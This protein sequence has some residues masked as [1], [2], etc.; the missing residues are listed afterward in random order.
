MI[1][2][3]KIIIGLSAKELPPVPNGANVRVHHKKS[4]STKAKVIDKAASPRNS[5]RCTNTRWYCASWKPYRSFAH[6]K[7]FMPQPY[8]LILIC[9]PTCQTSNKVTPC[10]QTYQDSHHTVNVFEM[11]QSHHS[12]RNMIQYKKLLLCIA[13]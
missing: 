11:P 7:P 4:W 6:K 13:F 1:S 12:D 5:L 2:R 3:K 10:F 9:Y 8:H